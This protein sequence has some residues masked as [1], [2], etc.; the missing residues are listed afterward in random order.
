MGASPTK[1]KSVS[2]SRVPKAQP[3]YFE[4]DT[5]MQLQSTIR[6]GESREEKR[7]ENPIEE[8]DDDEVETEKEKKLFNENELEKRKRKK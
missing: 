1:K 3:L 5:L 8:V 4:N 6:F 7:E 2:P